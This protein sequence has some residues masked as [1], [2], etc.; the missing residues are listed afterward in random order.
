M[1]NVYFTMYYEKGKKLLVEKQ[2]H[3]IRMLFQKWLQPYVEL[4]SVG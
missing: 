4:E 1:K 2:G 3:E